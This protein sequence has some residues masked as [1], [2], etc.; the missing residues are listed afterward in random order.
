MKDT[1]SLLSILKPVP[2]EKRRGER[3]QGDAPMQKGFA[4]RKR[5]ISSLTSRGT[6]RASERERERESEREREKERERERERGSITTASQTDAR[7]L[8]F[9]LAESRKSGLLATGG[10]GNL[11][12]KM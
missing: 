2:S 11:Y 3:D 5:G 6:R 1:S 10:T 8:P 12:L 4:E 7:R 9:P